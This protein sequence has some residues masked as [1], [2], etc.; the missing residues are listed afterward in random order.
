MNFT[1]DLHIH[2][3][4]SRATSREGTLPGLAAWAAIKGIDLVATGDFTH[5]AW[6]QAIRD[7]LVEAE[8]GL[9][10]LRDEPAIQAPPG[11]PPG[12]TKRAR[13]C[14]FLLSAEISSIYK[15]GGRVRKV[16]NLLYVPT[17]EAAAG[18]NRRLAAVGNIESDGR[19]ILGL[20]SR[21]LLE[22]LL[23]TDD[24]GFL[25]PAHVWTPWFSLFGSKSGFDTVEECF[26]DL[27]PHVFA[28]ETGLSSDPAMNRLVSALDRFSLISNSD[29][30][31][32]SKLGR[33]ANLFDTDFSFS[34]LRNALEKPDSGFAGTIEFFPDEGKYHL[35]GHRACGVC[36]EP[37]ETRKMKNIC[38]V[39]GKPLTV[40][41]LHRVLELADRAEPVHSAGAPRFH[42]LVPLPE[43]LGEILG[44]GPNTKGV[45]SQYAKVIEKIGSEF[46]LLLHAGLDEISQKASPVLAEAVGRMRRGKVIRQGGYDGEFGVIRVFEE[47]ELATFAGQMGLFGEGRR[48]LRKTKKPAGALFQKT[49]DSVEEHCPAPVAA[50]CNP[51]QEAAIVARDKRIVVTAGPGTGKTFTLVSRLVHML[52]RGHQQPGQT[53]VI[54]FT[55]RAAD[56][57]R[58]RLERELSGIGEKLFVG[59]FHSFCLGLLQ[60]EQAGLTVAGPE[61]RTALLK[62]LYADRTGAERNRLHRLL[63]AYY[64]GLVTGAPEPEAAEVVKVY[65]AALLERNSV[66]LGAIIPRCLQ[67][68]ATDRAF[69]R[70]LEAR[71]HHLYIDEFQDLNLAQYELVRI[72]SENAE[73]FAI[74]DPDQAIYGFR[75]SRPQYFFDFIERFEARP[76]ALMRNYRS[77]PH[78]LKAC[79]AVIARN[80]QP[81]REPAVASQSAERPQ[82]G[83]ASIEFHRAPTVKAEAE[84]IGER[85]E[86]LMGGLSH[87]GVDSSA[88]AGQGAGGFADF[89]V[90]YRLGQQA[91]PIRVALERRGIPVQV[92]DGE[93]FFRK[94]PLRLLDCL[95]R[96]AGREADFAV[97]L[98]LASLVNVASGD[99]YQ[100]VERAVSPSERFSRNR[101]EDLLLS[102]GP[103][104]GKLAGL[105]ARIHAFE[106][107]SLEKGVAAACRRELEGLNTTG[108]D[109]SA[110]ERFLQL[111]GLFG[112]DLALFARHL[113]RAGLE[114]VYDE[115][116]EA[117]T[118]MTMHSSKGLEFPIV[119]LAGL[120]EG[121]LP[122]TAV[123]NDR[124]KENEKEEEIREERRLFYVAA[125]RARDR[126]LLSA[127]ATRTLFGRQSAFPVSRFLGE[128]PARLLVR[129]A[130]E[131]GRRIKPVARQLRLF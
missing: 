117:V 41:V 45:Q 64:E 77:A 125:S 71:V 81:D 103:G 120:E 62:T 56:E 3:P 94:G 131:R 51:E 123:F 116:A 75:G 79:G 65:E 115:R 108:A 82:Q 25:V 100:R 78:I 69:R 109:Q 32:P 61:A 53:V 95:V 42:S 129:A 87:R 119:F 98:D 4:Y 10:R 60:E 124:Q 113:Q 44:Q 57:V 122:C 28:L 18:I 49:N 86:N 101:L 22:I 23:E 107:E 55:N 73:I 8:P 36:L 104:E 72:L 50:R 47:G 88:G 70:R 48:K 6:F 83:E 21:D 106:R 12:I 67:L 93:P 99:V 127:A 54:T 58:E 35:D 84:W 27:A 66:D 14:R 130:S 68:L 34:A 13:S 15:R 17:L 112:H 33:E 59:T 121:I 102:N 105:L 52:Q 24:T 26:G 16:H 38:P 9:F 118:L 43:V 97:F 40:G 46:F 128:I 7:Q 110:G 19:P 92:A 20:D 74:G 11:F 30:H 63:T 91:E 111:A 39:C 31:S 76:L 1:A 89:A 114:P 96:C 85:I 126:L 80:R 5:P 2:S 37:E 29:C 90:L